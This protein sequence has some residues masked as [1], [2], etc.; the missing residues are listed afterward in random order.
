MSY[1]LEMWKHARPKN[2][3]PSSTVFAVVKETNFEIETLNVLIMSIH[4]LDRSESRKNQMGLRLQLITQTLDLII[5][6]NIDNFFL[7]EM[8]KMLNSD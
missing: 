8:E 3:A 4:T 5:L 6:Y 7:Y 1:K 2:M